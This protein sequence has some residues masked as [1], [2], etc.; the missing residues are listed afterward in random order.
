L[1]EAPSVPKKLGGSVRTESEIRMDFGVVENSD[2]GQEK[3][4]KGRGETMMLFKNN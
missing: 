3:K 4:N 1:A 2:V